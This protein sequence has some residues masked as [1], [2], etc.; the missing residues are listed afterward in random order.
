[1]KVRKKAVTKS[2]RA[3]KSPAEVKSGSKNPR[4]SVLIADDHS[5]VR[6]GLVSLITRKADMTV[7]GEASNGREAV[8]LWKKHHPDIL[9]LDLRMPELDR[10]GAIKEACGRNLRA[11][12]SRGQT[13][14]TG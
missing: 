2:P 9:L 5:V 4:I 13:R 6:E 1:M 12:T 7:I 8:D 14:A 3:K 10:V 11:G